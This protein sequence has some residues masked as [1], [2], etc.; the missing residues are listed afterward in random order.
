VRAIDAQNMPLMTLRAGIRDLEEVGYG[1]IDSTTFVTHLQVGAETAADAPRLDEAHVRQIGEAV[2]KLRGLTAHDPVN[3][4]QITPGELDAQLRQTD[5][6]GDS[7]TVAHD[8][9][10]LR[11]LG[12]I[13]PKADLAAIEH[14]LTNEQVLGYYD[15]AS[16]VFYLITGKSPGAVE[17]M[18]Y[19]HEY[20]HA[21]QDQN[22]GLAPSTKQKLDGDSSL[23]LRALVEGDASLVE[24]MYGNQE[25]AIQEAL[26]AYVSAREVNQP[27]LQAAP[28]FLQNVFAFP[29]RQGLDFVTAVQK[30]GGW[31]AVNDLYDKPPASTEQILHP[32]RYRAGDK[33]VAVSLPDV[34]AKIGAPWQEAE[35]DVMGELGWRLALEPGLGPT[36]AAAAAAGW[37]G[38]HYVLLENQNDHT[39]SLAMRSVW[40]NTDEAQEFA[41]LLAASLSRRFGYSDETYDMLSANPLRIWQG[42]DA[43]WAVRVNG[44]TVD[45]TI[46]NGQEIVKKLMEAFAQ[47]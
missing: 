12:L 34:A 24:S 4:K 47:R 23:A 39:Y 22:F 15:T 36:A 31:T 46:G 11:L 33:P 43:W 44:K 18:T 7:T 21:L 29:Y 8:Q 1:L 26:Q 2:G 30:Q 38:D 9:A 13:D 37:G 6:A 5:K 19:A 20:T 3:F 16:K 32:E 40:D 28:A 35:S 25:L 42:E 17:R 10:L 45:V 27:A 41:A 14:D